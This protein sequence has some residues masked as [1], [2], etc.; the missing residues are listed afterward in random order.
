M[1]QLTFSVAVTNV[2]FHKHCV[3]W[4]FYFTSLLNSELKGDWLLLAKCIFWN[5]H[6]IISLDYPGA[7]YAVIVRSK[8]DNSG[9]TSRDYGNMGWER[10]KQ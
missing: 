5:I 6:R 3:D 10:I 2:I 7:P 1:G 4:K 8:N 9:V